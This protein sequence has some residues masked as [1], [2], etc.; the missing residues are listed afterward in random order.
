[1]TTP[2]RRIPARER[3]LAVRWLL[4]GLGI[5][6]L[7]FGI[8]LSIRAGLGTSPISSFP[9]VMGV[10]T[11]W[12]V[13]VWT[14]IMNLAFVVLQLLLLRSRYELLQL[15]QIPI[16]FG[17]GFL[18]DAAL[19]LTEWL[20]PTSYLGQWVWTIIAGIVVGAGVFVQVAP[21]IVYTAGEG[22]VMAISQ[23]SGAKFSTVKWAFDWSLVGIATVCSLLLL[24]R[25]EMVRE[26]TLAA[27]FLV[28]ATVRALGRLV[29]RF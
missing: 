23:V 28:G 22:A 19:A 5:T 6:I 27:A 11:P 3:S 16:A 1:M 15:L 8:A 7:S 13:G 18:T 25:V 9:A 12:S 24:G 26:G 20:H 21:R 29:A 14:T 17:F 4:F 10:A 2:P